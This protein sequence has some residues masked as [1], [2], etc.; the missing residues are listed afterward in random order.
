MVD[1]YYKVATC[2]KP[3]NLLPCC[4]DTLIYFSLHLKY[5]KI[6]TLLSLREF[7][8]LIFSSLADAMFFYE[9]QC[10]HYE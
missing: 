7:L 9:T 4:K 6:F 8:K 10:R 5:N 1:H 3:F 2:E